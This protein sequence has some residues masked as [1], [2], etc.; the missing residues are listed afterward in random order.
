MMAPNPNTLLTRWLERESIRIHGR[1]MR[2]PDLSFRWEKNPL[3][4]FVVVA[5][6]YCTERRTTPREHDLV[7]EFG[8]AVRSLPELDQ[9]LI[10]TRRIGS[11]AEWETLGMTMGLT[12]RTMTRRWRRS[13][14]T[15]L[16]EWVRRMQG[17]E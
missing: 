5:G 1:A 8:Y 16:R 4:H 15:L 2:L 6:G 9:A 7:D 11:T 12:P 3:G 14:M 10:I 13:W 17:W